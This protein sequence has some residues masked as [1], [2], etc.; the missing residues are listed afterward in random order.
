MKKFFKQLEFLF[1]LYFVYFLY[2]GKR[3]SKYY[4]YMNKKWG[5]ENK[6]TSK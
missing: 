4:E 1:D 2:N 3:I 6:G 5:D